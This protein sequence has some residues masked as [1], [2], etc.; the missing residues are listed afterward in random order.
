MT[1]YTTFVFC[2]ANLPARNALCKELNAR[3]PF[4]GEGLETR[5][6]AL[7]S[8]DAMSVSDAMV[9]ALDCTAIDLSERRELALEMAEALTWEGCLGVIAKWELAID[10]FGELVDAR[11]ASAGEAGTAETT[12]IGSVHEH[13]TAE[14]GDVHPTPSS[15]RGATR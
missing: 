4:G 14:S 1:E 2:H 12:E 9:L 15:S 7:S 5:I 6:T 11:T 13:A 10:E 3:F 8:G